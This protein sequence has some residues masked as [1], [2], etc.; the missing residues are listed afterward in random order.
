MNTVL[1][2]KAAAVTRAASGIDLTCVNE[3]LKARVQVVLI[4]SVVLH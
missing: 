1:K 2:G 3:F 4:D